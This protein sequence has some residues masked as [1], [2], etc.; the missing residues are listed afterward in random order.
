MKKEFKAPIVETRELA[1]RGSVM[2]D[3]DVLLIAGSQNDDKGFA[4]IEDSIK[5]GFNQWK[6]SLSN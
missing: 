3:N 5:E 1:T 4:S 2:A 6:G